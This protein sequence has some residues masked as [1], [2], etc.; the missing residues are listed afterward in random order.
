MT[1]PSCEKAAKV[2]AK[3]LISEHGGDPEQNATIHFLNFEK[4]R[5][6]ISFSAPMRFLFFRIP[7]NLGTR[8]LV[9][10]NIVRKANIPDHPEI[11]YQVCWYKLKPEKSDRPGERQLLRDSNVIITNII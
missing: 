10:I 6:Q 11:K 8:V 1:I 9:E 7:I 2:I 4:D 3:H 5:A